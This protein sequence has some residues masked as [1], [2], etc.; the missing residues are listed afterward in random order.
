MLVVMV[1]RTVTFDVSGT[2]LAEATAVMALRDRATLLRDRHQNS[3]SMLTGADTMTSDTSLACPFLTL[4][5]H[6]DVQ[7]R[8]RPT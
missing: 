3:V 4:D 7:R 2:G 6:G 5:D 8:C 1:F